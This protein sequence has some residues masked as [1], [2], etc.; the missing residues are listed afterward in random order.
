MAL[1]SCQSFGESVFALDDLS[2]IASASTERV[3]RTEY[4]IDDY[5]QNYF[6]ILSFEELLKHSRNRFRPALQLLETLPDI[7][8]AEILGDDVITH[9]TRRTMIA[10]G[11]EAKV[12]C[13]PPS[14]QPAAC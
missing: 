13:E 10:K 5:Q 12:A 8:I 4:R 6:V 11:V 3:M 9:G 2:P 7:K 14:S 1:A